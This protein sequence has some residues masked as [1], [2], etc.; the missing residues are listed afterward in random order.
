MTRLASDKALMQL[1][2]ERIDQ[3]DE[4]NPPELIP[5]PNMIQPKRYTKCTVMWSTFLLHFIKPIE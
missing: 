4:I 5:N 1:C 3:I 2:E